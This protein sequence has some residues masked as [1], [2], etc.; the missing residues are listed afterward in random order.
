M[1]EE[2]PGRKILEG[3]RNVVLD[4][5]N[6]TIRAQVRRIASFSAHADQAKLLEWLG[7]IKGVKSLCIVHGDTMQRQVFAEQAKSLGIPEINLPEMD[8][9]I[10]I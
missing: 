10:T 8:Q 7:H 4:K 6:I 3:A 5:K 1:A 2:T 9:V